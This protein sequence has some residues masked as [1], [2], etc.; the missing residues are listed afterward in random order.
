MAGEGSSLN[1]VIIEKLTH[2]SCQAWHCKMMTLLIDRGL[3][4][5]ALGGE[6]CSEAVSESEKARF[7]RR[8]QKALALIGLHVGGEHLPHILAAKDPK[9]L[10]ADLEKPHKEESQALR[11]H[12]RR[13]LQRMKMPKDASVAIFM[14]RVKEAANK[15]KSAGCLTEEDEIV[16][17]ALSGLPEERSAIAAAMENGGDPLAAATITPKL[18][19]HEAKAHEDEN[20]S[21][22]GGKD[23]RAFNA[24]ET[25]RRFICKKKGHIA[26][27]CRNRKCENGGRSSSKG[28]NSDQNNGS[29]EETAGAAFLAAQELKSEKEIGRRWIMGSGASSHMTCSKTWLARM[30]RSSDLGFVKMG[31]GHKI[32]MPGIGEARIDAASSREKSAIALKEALLAPEMSTNLISAPRAAS[33]GLGANFIGN[34]PQIKGKDGKTRARGV[35][36]DNLCC[37]LGKTQNE[38]QKTKDESAMAANEQSAK[39]RRCRLGHLSHPDAKRL[40]NGV[41]SGIKINEKANENEACEPCVKGKSHREAMPKPR[42]EG[43]KESLQLAH[44]DLRRPITPAALGGAK[45]LMTLIG[46]YARHSWARLLKRKSD[47]PENVKAWISHVENQ[48]NKKVKALRSDRG[49]E[50]ISE[51]LEECFKKKGIKQETAVACAP[52]QNGAAERLNRALAEKARSMLLQMPEESKRLWAEALSAANYARNRSPTQALKDVTPFEKLN[53]RK[54]NLSHLRAFGR[55]AYAHAHKDQGRKKLDSKVKEGVFAGYSARA[56]GYRIYA[57]ESRD[58]ET[59]R[60]AAFGE[61]EIVKRNAN[62]ETNRALEFAGMKDLQADQEERNDAEEVRRAYPQRER[63]QARFYEPGEEAAETAAAAFAEPKACKEALK[64]SDHEMRSSAISD[65][66]ISLIK[67]GA[68]SLCESPEGREAIK[69]KWA[70]KLKRDENGKVARHKTRLAAKGCAQRPGIDCDEIF[71]PVSRF[72]ALRALL[73]AAAA[74]DLEIMQVDIKAAFLSGKLE[75]EVCM[76]Q[77][78][79][80][81]K[82]SSLACRLWKT[83]CGLKQAPRAWR[84]CLPKH[85][86]DLGFKQSNAHPGLFTKLG[87][88]GRIFMLICADDLL[89]LGKGVDDIERILS[90]MGKKFDMRRLG[91]VRC[92]LG[93]KIARDRSSRRIMLSQEQRAWQLLRRFK[94]EDCHISKA[95]MQAGRNLSQSMKPSSEAEQEEMERAPYQSLAGGLMHLS[96]CARPDISY[97]VGILPRLMQDPGMS[98]WKAAKGALKYLKGAS[99][100]TLA[101]A[102]DVNAKSY[103]DADYASDIDARRSTAGF[104]VNIGSGSVSWGSRLQNAVALSTAEA[105]CMAATEISKELLWLK[106]LVGDLGI[107]ED[108]KTLLINCDNQSCAKLIKNPGLHKR[109]KRIDIRHHFMRD[110]AEDGVMK[111]IYCSANEM[112]A[113]MLTKAAPGSKVEACM[114]GMGIID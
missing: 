49:G 52:S 11:A 74:E 79:G 58:V 110:L 3:W 81:I 76:E 113:D 33:S 66:C 73:S 1:E 12:L 37:L 101:H 55:E 7:K 43:A 105:E 95:S 19:R 85:L 6:A 112:I 107:H 94:M 22:N 57:S 31:D 106:K 8:E 46:D 4:D 96:N 30:K 13:Q 51:T 65:E 16:C 72:S 45:C 80:H 103:C 97:A 75:E 90:S 104:V 111:F 83:I 102:K 5:I 34:Q 93:I 15:L 14:K 68:W 40:S 21:G 39:L 42:S 61:N 28:Q 47:A 32:Q 10:W 67:S 64:S 71:A 82:N 60:D 35:K 29:K 17:V 27:N 56:R 18:L 89:A 99:K 77:P 63:K 91:S 9:A 38:S 100:K 98:H 88:S 92:F 48:H 78:E 109:S 20:G 59:R 26:R 69:S 114:S 54:P 86:G 108:L 62:D 41:A 23:E 24:R 70:L 50:H 53:Q 84:K 2:E 87:G 36:D 44:S 25:R